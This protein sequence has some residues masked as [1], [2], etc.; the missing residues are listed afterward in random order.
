M[1]KILTIGP[2]PYRSKGGMATVIKGMEEDHKLNSEFDLDVYESYIDGNLVIRLFFS[3]HSFIRF[4]FIYKKYDVFHIHVACY[5]S[6][7]RK[8]MYVRFLKKRAKKVILHV[9]G[10]EYLVFYNKLSNK[11]KKIVK[12]IWH[13]CDVIIALSEEWKIEFEKIFQHP[14][15]VVINNGIDVQK[16]KEGRNSIES[17]NKNFLFLG[18]LGKRK[19]AWDVLEAVKKIKNIY[20]DIKVYM[21]GD[22]E[23][24]KVKEKV[25]AEDLTHQIFVVGWIDYGQKIELMKKTATLLLPSY[26]EGLPMSILESMAAGKVILTTDV[27]GIPAVIKNNENGIVIKPGDIDALAN[28][29]ISIIE[30]DDFVIRCSDNNLKK[31]EDYFS[32]EKTHRKIM[33]VYNV[34]L[35]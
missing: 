14:R 6:T 21:A 17:Y 29:M 35:K 19:G 13:K 11:R 33:D 22:G 15:I 12:D 9:H 30:N 4:C 20:P 32:I 25:G 18:R 27:G 23:I 28:A 2:S 1:T 7:F 5:G 34:V 10:A 31:I 8:G 24:E 16:F 26:N 3:I